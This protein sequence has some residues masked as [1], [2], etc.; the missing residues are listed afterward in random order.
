MPKMAFF[1]GP[2]AGPSGSKLCLSYKSTG[3]SMRR[4]ASICHCGEP[5]QIESVSYSTPPTPNPLINIPQ[6]C[7]CEPWMCNCQRTER[8][9]DVGVHIRHPVFF[10]DSSHLVN[11]RQTSSP[12]KCFA[13]P[14]CVTPHFQAGMINVEIQIEPILNSLPEIIQQRIVPVWD[15]LVVN[16]QYPFVDAD[17]SDA[18]LARFLIG[19]VG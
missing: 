8:E 3:I 11:P 9:T 6:H 14:V 13:H 19:R 10:G 18:V 1:T 5:A 4:N 15:P 17:I 2:S 7:R 12:F 16:R